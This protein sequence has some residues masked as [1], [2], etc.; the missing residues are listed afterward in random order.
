MTKAQ[1]AKL[2][3]FM[4]ATRRMFGHP[5]LARVNDCTQSEFNK[6][7]G[8]LRASVF[9]EWTGLSREELDDEVR[10]GHIETYQKPDGGQRWY[11][12]REIARMTGFKL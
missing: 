1:E 5:R 8:L 12:K 9:M 10:S 4:E 7:P 6:L 3:E 2:D 11:Y